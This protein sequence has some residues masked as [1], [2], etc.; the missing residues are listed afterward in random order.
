MQS[1]LVMRS[2]LRPVA[3]REARRL[4]LE[5]VLD[6]IVPQAVV[7]ACNTALAALAASVLSLSQVLPIPV[8]RR[9][10]DVC[11]CVFDK[12]RMTILTEAFLIPLT[13]LGYV[14]DDRQTGG[15]RRRS[16][17]R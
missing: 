5:I 2:W 10:L 16:R 13:G 9:L 14:F 17:R 15:C 11:L 3:D 4:N 8:P 6:G 12:F 7:S 1:L